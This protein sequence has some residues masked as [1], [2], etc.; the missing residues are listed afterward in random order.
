MVDSLGFMLEIP[1]FKDSE[2]MNFELI[3][4]TLV[5]FKRFM[6]ESQ[7]LVNFKIVDFGFVIINSNF[8]GFKINFK[9]INF[10]L[11]GY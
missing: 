4:F 1:N 11:M 5:S 6:F 10:E 7:D 9:L 3:R 2:L 8:V